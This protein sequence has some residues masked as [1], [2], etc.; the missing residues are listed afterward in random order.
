MKDEL[1]FNNPSFLNK[2]ND[3]T[4]LVVLPTD[5]GNF[6]SLN[7]DLQGRLPVIATNVNL[8]ITSPGT[9]NPSMECTGLDFV[10]TN[11]P[12]EK[13]TFQECTNK[14]ETEFRIPQTQIRNLFKNAEYTYAALPDSD[15]KYYLDTFKK[16]IESVDPK[17]PVV[18]TKNVQ[19]NFGMKSGCEHCKNCKNCKNGNGNG[20]GNG[21]LLFLFMLIVLIAI[22]TVMFIKK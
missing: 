17:K 12:Y 1:N 14:F 21:N 6:G 5:Y 11:P 18:P 3:T 10:N 20:N 22:I 13:L 2:N 8:G 4:S 19:E 7:P 15:K 9:L 16:F